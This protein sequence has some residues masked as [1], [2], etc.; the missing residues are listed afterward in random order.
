[1]TRFGL[2]LWAYAL[3]SIEVPEIVDGVEGRRVVR[4]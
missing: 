3:A 2:S 1:M 4:S